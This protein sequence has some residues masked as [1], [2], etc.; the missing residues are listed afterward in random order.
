MVL[1]RAVLPIRLAS[2]LW[3]FGAL[4]ACSSPPEPGTPCKGGGETVSC[5]GGVEVCTPCT[6]LG[7]STCANP[8][9][10]MFYWSECKPANATGTT[11]SGTTGSG[12]AC[13]PSFFGNHDGCHCGC[14]VIDPDCIDATAGSC[15]FC[16]KK[17]SCSQASVGCPGTINPTNNAVCN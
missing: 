8:D 2:T 14:G 13:D 11:G 3:A 10:D 16:D 6:T 5:D 15:D 1:Q 9:V 7:A 4:S 17:S 12:W